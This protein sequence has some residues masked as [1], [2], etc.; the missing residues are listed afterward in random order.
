MS[1]SR[2]DNRLLD[3]DINTNDTSTPTQVPI[4]DPVTHTHARK[5]NHQVS[6][7]FISCP[8]CLDHGDACTLIFLRIQGD[9]RK[10]NGFAH[11]GFGLQNS[12]KL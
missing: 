2:V 7:L 8:S 11:A 5:Y 3:E 4:A 6:S 9:D 12:T 10:G 1:R